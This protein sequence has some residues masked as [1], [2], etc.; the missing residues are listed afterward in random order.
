[1]SVVAEVRGGAEW[2]VAQSPVVAEAVEIDDL[3][4]GIAGDARLFGA[5]ALGSMEIDGAVEEFVADL[6]AWHGEF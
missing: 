5:D 1:M 2:H 3:L 6:I 4:A